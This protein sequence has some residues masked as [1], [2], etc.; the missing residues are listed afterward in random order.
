MRT[1]EAETTNEVEEQW[2]LTSSVSTYGNDNTRIS[3]SKED[4]LY[5][6]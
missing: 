2:E 6:V 3:Y 5:L 1:K 4:Q